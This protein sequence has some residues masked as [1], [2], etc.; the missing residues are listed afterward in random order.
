MIRKPWGL[1][2]RRLFWN[3]GFAALAALIFFAGAPAAM[4]HG[5]PAPVTSDTGAG[6][7]SDQ[8]VLRLNMAGTIA[9]RCSIDLG[10]VRA[11]LD[12]S[13]RTG[14]QRFTFGINCNDQMVMRLRSRSG[15]M[16]HEKSDTLTPSPFFDSQQPY[17]VKVQLGA[18]ETPVEFESRDLGQQWGSVTTAHIPGIDRG[19]LDI[20]WN[21][22]LPLL[23]GQYHDI[24][25]IRIS[26]AGESDGRD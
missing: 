9:P 14:T 7:A 22:T 4:A 19:A 23:G 2:V 3:R 25:E 10:D 11:N 18:A 12:L 24:L 16:I 20:S 8:A 5:G 15:A 1:G 6:E 26:A 17:R 13:Q 21:R